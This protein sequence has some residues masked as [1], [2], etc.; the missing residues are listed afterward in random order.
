MYSN[1][2]LYSE[3]IR[4]R[5]KLQD[6]KEILLDQNTADPKIWG[7]PFWTSLHISAAF[8]PMDASPITQKR[9]HDRILAIPYEIACERCRSHALAFIESYSDQLHRIVKNRHSLGKFYVDFHNQVNK[10]HNKP[11]WTYE[12]AYNYYRNGMMKS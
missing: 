1:M 7:P 2:Q 8:Y 5:S 3:K 10:R 6:S 9:I 4:P 12:K 11:T